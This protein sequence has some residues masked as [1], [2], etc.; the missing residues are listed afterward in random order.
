VHYY[1]FNVADWQSSTRHLTP[2]EEGV[3]LRLINHYYDT[4][5]PIPL[6]TQPVIRRLCLGSCSVIALSIL[7]EFFVKTDRGYEKEKCND[8][9]KDYKKRANKNRKNGALGGRP[10]KHAASEETQSVAS[11]MPEVT[12][13]EP[14][15][16]LN[17]ELRTKNQEPLTTN[18]NIKDIAAPSAPKR[19]TKRFQVP[20]LDDVSGYCIER[21]NFV[22]AER[23]IDHYTSN[24]WKVGK[25]P[26]K[27][28]KSAVRTWEKNSTVQ[29]V[30]KSNR[31]PH[32]NQQ[33]FLDDDGGVSFI[34][35]ELVSGQ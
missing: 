10:R 27:D 25:N 8:I 30:T 23:F 9:I 11:G 12:Q 26:M 31:T 24:G 32:A 17:Q 29:P 21:K 2:E 3:Y 28:W 5:K 16:N 6:D 1:N 7:D 14:K 19:A 13:D 22:D 15:H 35:G 18:H 33:G 4:E 20:T 34:D